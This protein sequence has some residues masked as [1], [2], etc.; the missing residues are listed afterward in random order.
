M[1]A[2]PLRSSHAPSNPLLPPVR[3]PDVNQRNQADEDVVDPLGSPDTSDG[4]GLRHQE[5]LDDVD[6]K[7]AELQGHGR[8]GVARARDGLEEGHGEGTQQCGDTNHIDRRHCR[9]R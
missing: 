9:P 3:L 8:R 7:D 2:L 6:D 5:D 1:T 4:G